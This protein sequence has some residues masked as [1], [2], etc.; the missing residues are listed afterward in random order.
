MNNLDEWRYSSYHSLLS[1]KSTKLKCE[2]V[3]NWFGNKE[4]FIDFHK[5]NQV[6]LN[7]EFEF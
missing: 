6:I 2:E 4:K 1:E 3:I 7:E 5:Q